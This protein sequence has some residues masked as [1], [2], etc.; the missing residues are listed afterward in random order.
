M[1]KAL[2]LLCLL[3]LLYGCE[4][5]P[6]LI[7]PENPTKAILVFPYENSACN[8]GTN[9]TILESTVLFEWEA[10]KNSDKYELML[11][12]L[13][14]G[15]ITTCETSNTEVPVILKRAT[16]YAWY[17][18]SKSNSVSDTAR[19]ATWK[20]YN[21]GDGIKSY[22]PFPA[23][24]ISPAMAAT[25][26]TASSVITLDWNGSD[27]DGDITGY[28]VYFG[29]IA[30]PGIFKSD[31]PESILLNVPIA[32]KTIYFWKIVTKDSRGNKSD[33]GVYQFKIN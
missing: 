9:L 25:I 21:A 19:S 16:P 30:A 26:S 23:E 13:S 2:F 12:S 14:T 29:T 15:A 33:S 22:A 4:K 27:V 10:G 20:F 6:V 11:K 3:L 31:Q 7:I 24:I 32:S 18:I 8:E 28:D 17:V 1:K 5:K